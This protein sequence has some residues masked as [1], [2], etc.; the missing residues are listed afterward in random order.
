MF[1]LPNI[2]ALIVIAGLL[3]VMA[4]C[5]TP[6]PTPSIRPRPGSPT[7]AP[8][9]VTPTPVS[10]TIPYSAALQKRFV[11]I[12]SDR[13]IG[14]LGTLVDAGSRHALSTLKNP[15]RGIF[16]ARTTLVGAFNAIKAGAPNASI[17]VWTQPVPIL[18]NGFQSTTDNV[19]MVMPGSAID[20]GVI[21][22][23][24]HYDTIIATDFFNS[25]AR[26]PG[27]NANGSGVAVMLEVARLMAATP[28][29]AT[30]LFVA[31]TASETGRQGSTAFIKQYLDQQQPPIIP[32]AMINLDTVGANRRASG[33]EGLNELRI[34]SAD[35]NE[36]RSRQLARYLK[37]ITD[38][39]P[40][41]PD[42]L[43]NS[44]LNL[45]RLDLQ[46]A[47]TR[48][49]RFSDHQSFSAQGI[50]AI[51]LIESYEDANR[52]R[53]ERDTLDLIRPDY[54]MGVTRL[55]LVALTGLADGLSYPAGFA[56]RD[57]ET[58]DLPILTW[59]AVPNAA[60]YVVAVRS[61]PSLQ[62]EQLFVTSAVP[63]LGWAGFSRYDLAAVGTMDNQGVIGQFSPE[64]SLAA[65][66]K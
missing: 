46:A 59:R 29:R 1:I 51:Q 7:A 8:A 22:I 49:G 5:D 16:A 56:F 18:V 52:Q 2:R 28:H 38:A 55:T 31:F 61:L 36:S 58:R 11:L 53:T 4:A 42:D 33:V 10:Q 45:P 27:A 50:G 47:E 66:G 40:V 12:Q 48:F 21:V 34:F 9:R 23:G 65:L 35:P 17:E 6:T 57:R 43:N 20:A 62:F 64:F 3:L 14:T 26:S 60:G 19:V 30:I 37:V 25:S 54:L 13:L 63:E 32:R 41:S 39:Y 24:A 15:S 44:S